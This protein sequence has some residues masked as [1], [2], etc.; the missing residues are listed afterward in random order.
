M[1]LKALVDMPNLTGKIVTQKKKG[2][3]YIFYEYDRVYDPVRKYHVPK[4][5]VIG[6]LSADDAGTMY[7]NP[8]FLKFFPSVQVSSMNSEIS[9]SCCLRIGSWV[10]IE[11]IIKYCGLCYA[12]KKDLQTKELAAAIEKSG[13]TYEDVLTFVKSGKR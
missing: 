5:S 11:H 3:T 6:K 1:Y 9:R 10:V 4:R 13:K 2:S 7:P 8:N 12:E